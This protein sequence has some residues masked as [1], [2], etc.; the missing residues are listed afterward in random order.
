MMKVFIVDDHVLFREGLASLL[1]S[2]VD[3]HVV[4]EAGSAKSAIAK[5]P[6]QDPDL[7]LLDITLPDGDGLEVLHAIL[8]NK[9]GTRV[10]ML[11]IHESDDVL[12]AALRAGARGYLL[13]GTPIKNLLASLRAID[14]GEPALT[15]SMTGRLV[16]EFSRI[17]ALDEGSQDLSPL[18]PRELEV[19]AELGKDASN[20]EI[21]ERLVI[22]ENTVKVHIHNILKKLNLQN[23]GEAGRFFRRNRPAKRFG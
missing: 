18:T 6:N 23:R 3:F 12:F 4:G 11:T 20:S 8:Q 10:V 2:Q 9:P 15:R 19:L 22:T 17:S 13:K 7:V 21:A 5:I 1:E 16:E 14:R